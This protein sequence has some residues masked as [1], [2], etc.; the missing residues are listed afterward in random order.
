MA[1]GDE[2][3]VSSTTP[4]FSDELHHYQPEPEPGS[5]SGSGSEMDQAK[6][7]F[8]SSDDIVDLVG[9]A[10]DALER[11]KAEDSSLLDFTETSFAPPKE[12]V[13]LPEPEPVSAP[14]VKDPE[15]EVE[16]AI[17]DST[18]SSFVPEFQFVA[19]EPEVVA[20]K[21]EPESTTI[22]PEPQ[23]APDSDALPAAEPRKAAPAPVKAAER[24]AVTEEAPAP[25]SYV[26][27]LSTAQTHP[28]MQF[29][30]ALGQKGDSPAPI[31][32][33]SPLH[34]PDSLEEL[35]LTESPNQPPVS[36]SAAPLG[37]FSTEPPT[38][39]SKDMLWESE[40]GDTGPSHSK[41]K[42]DLLDP[43]AG[44]YLSL[45]KDPGP[46]N[47]CE[48]SGVSFSPEEKLISS[49]RSSDT[50]PSPVNPQMKVPESDLASSNPTEHW[51]SPLL[52]TQDSPKV[53]MDSFSKDTAPISSSRYEP[54]L[55]S[56]QSDEDDDLMYEVKKNNNPF[57][58]YSPLADSGYSHF[59]DS[60]SDS[61]ASK[62]SESPTPDLVQYGQTGESQ[63]SP[64]SFLDEAKTFET[65]KMAAESL[66]QSVNQF[67]SGLKDDDEDE[68]EDSALP[69]SL[70]D[71][72]K[73]SPLNPDKIDSGSSEGSPEEQSPI[74]ERRMMESPN[75]PI[76]LSANNPFAFD[77]KVSLLK[78]MAEEMEEKAADKAKTDDDKSF[79]AFDLVKEAE[80][81]TP[82]KVKEEEPVKIEQRDWFSSHDS[83]KITEKFEP[84][85]FQSKKTLAEDS[86]SES[87]TADSLSPVLEAMAK[88]PAIFQV[89][90]E[91]KDLKME[92]EEAEVAEEVSEHEVSSEEFEFI[93]R[94]PKGVIDEFLE[95]L[96]TSKFASSKPP[97]IPMDDDLSFGQK[98]ASP[99][100]A[101]PP[102]VTPPPEV[103][104]EAPSQTSYLLL[105]QASPQKIKAEL[106]K[107]D[108][109]KPPS[110]VP[111]THSPV[112]KPDEV[113]A[114]TSVEG[115][116]LFKMPNVN[117]RAVVDLLYWRDVKT[118]G[119]VFGAALLLLL[120]LTV[121][122]IVSV[123]SYIGLALLSVTVCFRIYKGILQAIQKSDEGHPFK[124]Y[125]DQDV[126][127][128]EDTVH[129]YSDVVLAKL[130]KII[131][132]LR[133][134]FLVEDLVDSIKFA[135][136]MWILTYVGALFNGL[137]LL[138]LGLIGAFSC[139][140][141]YEK[142]QAQIDH[143]LALVNNQIKDIVGKIQAKVPGMK[144]KTE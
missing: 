39:H 28:L 25:A 64:P 14:G 30:T 121:C 3:H 22:V 126:S 130:N 88:N 94:P 109:Q 108:I 128:S 72:L 127:L 144:R 12:P 137:T 135:V 81:T 115:G 114:K 67:S 59:G 6:Q 10:R 106:E 37:S 93:E 78:E 74:L 21:A 7:D 104:E 138:I 95:A 49:D 107:L 131:V 54:D 84:L 71:I 23:A 40:E 56:N 133:R 98:D 18:S 68:E 5:G 102:K 46:H 87:P 26:P 83:P 85:D 43:L 48:D 103:E 47:P 73:S 8:F 70:P 119:V 140:I 11:H 4:L 96:D 36:G 44:P 90:T 105:T 52:A 123:S 134:L 27:S 1:D 58:G 125:L 75:P 80:E 118:T 42:E 9:G 50:G 124:Q 79:G 69:P 120:S 13:T 35:S 122:S 19:A 38:A 20:P 86:D 142:H 55:H 77:A 17:P 97:E 53:S 99:V 29:P 16:N 65:G 91:K 132:D 61:R 62:M 82:T 60:K 41:N 2:Q 33:I 117:I 141:I 15:T 51:D 92:V 116:K 76:N 112:C 100:S 143:Y 136:L 45:G 111:L 89:E 32:P 63:D 101:P 24:P 66:M 31:S 57:E 34:S 129:K 139:P 113:V 110:H